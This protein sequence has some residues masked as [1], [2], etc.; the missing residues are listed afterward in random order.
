MRA[1]RGDSGVGSNPDEEGNL[2]IGSVHYTA[3]A[4]CAIL[5]GQALF[6][7]R[8]GRFQ[9]RRRPVAGFPRQAPG[10]IAFPRTSLCYSRRHLIFMCRCHE[11]RHRAGYGLSTE[12]QYFG[13]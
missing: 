7:V 13:V 10:S 6:R 9:L 12:L 4:R 8:R 11:M 5:W 3:Q 2:P 1:P